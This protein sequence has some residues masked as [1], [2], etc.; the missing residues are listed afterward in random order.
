MLT[1]PIMEEARRKH[2]TPEIQKQVDLQVMIANL[3]YYLLNCF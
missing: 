3:I 2:L 1:N